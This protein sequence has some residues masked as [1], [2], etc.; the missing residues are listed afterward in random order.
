MP[1]LARAA[2]NDALLDGVGVRAGV[3]GLGGQVPMG[4][5]DTGDVVGV[6][7]HPGR[8]LRRGGGRDTVPERLPGQCSSPG[9][10]ER[11]PYRDTSREL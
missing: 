4:V 7:I 8:E 9:I 10:P 6:V 11:D 3:G 5:G 1:A 2:S